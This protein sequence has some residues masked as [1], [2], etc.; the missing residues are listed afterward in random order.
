MGQDTLILTLVLFNIFFTAFI[1]GIILFIKEYRKKK[2]IHQE[3]LE[4]IDLLHQEELLK[5]QNEIQK[6]TMQ[7]IG[8]EI[9]DNVGQKLTLS[10]I[11]LQQLVF[12]NKFPQLNTTINNINDII[13]E[14]LT[15]LRQL[16]KSLTDDAIK[17]SSL[18]DLI[19]QESTRVNQLETCKIKFKN[20]LTTNITSYK[21][22]SILLRIVQEFIQNSL[23]HSN[24]KII[25]IDLL[26][27]E[28]TLTLLL[29]D[30]GKGFDINTIESSG[31]GLKNIYK[32]IKILN[33]SSI[34]QSDK[35]GTELTVNIPIL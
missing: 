3:E 18:V 4:T 9:H 2:K 14:S 1:T 6:E 7:H 34:L 23:K 33:G 20:S 26:N 10:S 35:T 27:N 8:K 12:E 31:I 24:C 21:T 11:Y 25:S 13:N 19:S 15:E 30:D 29:S 28:N 5:T 32:R 16:S 22:K 17:N